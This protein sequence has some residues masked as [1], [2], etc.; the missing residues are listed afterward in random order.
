MEFQSGPDAP[1]KP[2]EIIAMQ[3]N[4][5]DSY[6]TFNV[7]AEKAT[8]SSWSIAITDETGMVQNFGPYTQEWASIPGKSIL[9]T[10][11]EG[12]Y[13]VTMTGQRMNGQIAKR[14]TTVHLVLWTPPKDEE[15]M[16]FSIIYEFNNSKAIAMYEKYLTQIVI[17]KIPD[18]GIVIIHGY[19]DNI[20]DESYNQKLS[21]ARANDVREIF[22]KELS[23]ENRIDV[24]FEIYG[25]G[26]DPE[27]SPFE[28]K[29]P[30]E[31]FYNRTV[32]IDIIP[33]SK[34]PNRVYFPLKKRL[35]KNKIRQSLF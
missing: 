14:D 6:V 21:L 3:A 19:T 30:E 11:L 12:N 29:F 32:I 20:G 25:F 17:P 5:F 26:E 18:G 27:F 31:R 33:G 2:V 35:S 28:N 13:K 22:V 23:K 4:P 7:E 15:M 24:K 10:R 8:F 1:L 16:R 34:F 9:G